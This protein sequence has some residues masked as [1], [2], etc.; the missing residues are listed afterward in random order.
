MEKKNN[1]FNWKHLVGFIAVFITVYALL[2]YLPD[3]LRSFIEQ[4]FNK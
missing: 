1:K 2:E 4:G 3:I